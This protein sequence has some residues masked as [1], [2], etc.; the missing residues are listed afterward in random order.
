MALGF[1]IPATAFWRSLLLVKPQRQLIELYEFL[2]VF[3]FSSSLIAVFEP[4]FF[5]QQNIP[6]WQISLFYGI[7]YVLY[8]LLLPLGGKFTAR[9]GLERSLALSTPIYV[10]YFLALALLPTLPAMFWIGIVLLTLHKIF[11]WPAFHAEFSKYGNGHTRGQ[12]MSWQTVTTSG[13]GVV[14]PVI[15]GIV[16]SLF[17]FPTMFV[18]AAM[19]VMLASFPLLRTRE[20][21][22]P[23]QFT[24]S[25]PWKLMRSPLHRRMVVSM[26]GMAENLVDL[27]HWPIFL[28]IV[29]GAVTPTI[30]SYRL[31]PAAALGIISS[32]TILIMT[33][34][35]FFIGK[36][37]DRMSGRKILQL[38]LPFMM[39]SYLFRP[40]SGGLIAIFLTS[41]L[42]RLAYIGVRVPMVAQLYAS[43][44][45]A[46]PLQYAVTFE[47]VLAI[48]KAI[49]AL[50]LAWVFFAFL[51]YTAFLVSFLLAAGFS[52]LY[53]FL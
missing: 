49:T 8:V 34:V 14:S 13:I 9:Y 3:S 22:R 36:M 50:V 5:Y 29:L 40:I 51:P 7:H 41:T 42:A 16:A 44:H 31:D 11:Y 28:F 4:V 52:A 23:S 12:E 43:A 48:S 27:V 37:S 24:Y 21:G 45:K 39:I 35:G 32:I 26:V 25:A 10:L 2:L 18:L 20:S 38:H 30:F 6:L 33:F 46:G 17:G 47:M 15:G 19:T 1:S 53:F